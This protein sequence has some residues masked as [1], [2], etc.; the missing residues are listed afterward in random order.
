MLELSPHMP[1]RIISKKK[2]KHLL[3]IR[4]YFLQA[5][6][7]CLEKKTKRYRILRGNKSLC[8]YYIE[9]LHIA[10]KHEKYKL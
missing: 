6:S 1:T 3:W 8:E 7:Q 9:K 10:V 4:P 5:Y 2:W